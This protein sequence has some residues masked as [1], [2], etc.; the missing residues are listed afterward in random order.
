[1]SKRECSYPGCPNIT[2]RGSGRCHEHRYADRGTRPLRPR[3]ESI[4]PDSASAGPGASSDH[5][6]RDSQRRR[7]RAR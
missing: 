6:D 1:M 3:P 7:S 2:R 4:P 5:T